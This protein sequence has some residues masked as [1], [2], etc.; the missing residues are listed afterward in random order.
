MI[1]KS[2]NTEFSDNRS[3]G[4]IKC[5]DHVWV[6]WGEIDGATFF[7]ESWNRFVL[8][9]PLNDS[10]GP[11]YWH[12]RN[13]FLNG[14]I[15]LVK[16]LQL[17]GF[18]K[19]FCSINDQLSAI[20]LAESARLCKNIV[21]GW[22]DEFS[23]MVRRPKQFSMSPEMLE[24]FYSTVRK[25]DKNLSVGVVV[26]GEHLDMDY[27]KYL[28][29]IDFVTMFVYIPQDLKNLDSYMELC[30][31][32]FPGKRVI[33][34]LY[35]YDFAL[36][37]PMPMELLKFEFEAAARYI[38][39]GKIDSFI[40]LGANVIELARDRATWVKNFLEENYVIEVEHGSLWSAED[41]LSH[42]DNET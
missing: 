7:E 5:N 20:Q 32:A 34:G 1:E 9:H 31:R 17:F 38:R 41:K 16:Y 42:V 19:I 28:P 25:Y 8:P 12:A 15:E 27:T 11:A 29:Y 24:Q 21:G 37:R 22:V 13:I 40:V 23:W 33:L 36:R 30:S 2:I 4:M 6:W 35:I 18:E 14:G 26:Y 39:E 3:E 10:R